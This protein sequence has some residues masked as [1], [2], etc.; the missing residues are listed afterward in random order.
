[1]VC[2][3]IGFRSYWCF[4]LLFFGLTGVLSF[5]Y[6]A[7][8]VFGVNGVVLFRFGCIWLRA[9]CTTRQKVVT[10]Q[11]GGGIS[12]KFQGVSRG[13]KGLVLKGRGANSSHFWSSRIYRDH[14]NTQDKTGA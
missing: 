5:W 4:V 8:L 6:L 11:P 13:F 3:L 12:M 14:V 1:M 7:F 2:G 9:E 10:S